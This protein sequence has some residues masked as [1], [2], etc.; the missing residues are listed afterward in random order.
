VTPAADRGRCPAPGAA[1]RS[2]QGFSLIELMLVCLMIAPV[3]GALLSVS[4]VVGGT[5]TANEGNA[6]AASQANA[7]SLKV[8]SWVRTA[9]LTSLRCKTGPGSYV[10]PVDDTDYDA[11]QFQLVVDFAADLTPQ[12]GGV[13]TLAFQRE[14]AEAPNGTDDDGDGLVDE[15][16]IV[17][18]DDLGRRLGVVANVESLAIR[19][20]GRSVTVTVSAA[21]RDARGHVHRTVA[22]QR[23]LVQNN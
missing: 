17:M 21:V 13:R 7:A 14:P 4:G 2:T 11:A 15:G 22:Q 20:A 9:S 12:L 16:R 18:T 8:A 6:Q 3:L 23:V 19:K 1:E 10:D 5:L